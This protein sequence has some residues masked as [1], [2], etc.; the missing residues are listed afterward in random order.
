ML[1]GTMFF[2]RIVLLHIPRVAAAIR[3]GNEVT[4]LFVAVAMCGLS[5]ALAGT[6]RKDL[7]ERGAVIL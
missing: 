4:S 3:N 2:L 1:L 5:F 7:E 6:Y